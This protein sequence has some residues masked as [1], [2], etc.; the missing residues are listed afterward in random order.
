MNLKLLSLYLSS[1][2]EYT[3]YSLPAP[4]YPIE[5]RKQDVPVYII[6]AVLGCFSVVGMIASPIIG[7]YLARI[8]R[9]TSFVIAMALTGVG[10]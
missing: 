6:G 8:G 9:R 4:F 10:V 2:L 5:A 3:M 7:V 1:F